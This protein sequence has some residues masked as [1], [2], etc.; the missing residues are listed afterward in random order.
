MF[1]CAKFFLAS[2]GFSCDT[3]QIRAMRSGKMTGKSQ[4]IQIELTAGNPDASQITNVMDPT[5]EKL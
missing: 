3:C 1:V 5:G 2:L 4:G